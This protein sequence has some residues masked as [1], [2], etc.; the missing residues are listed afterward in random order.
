MLEDDKTLI[1][2]FELGDEFSQ[3]A[4][5][6]KE[7]LEPVLL[8]QTEDNPDALI[9]TV[10]TPDYGEPIRGFVELVRRGEP[11]VTGERQTD[12]VRVLAYFFRKTLELTRKR[13]PTEKIRLMCVT[14]EEMD[15]DFVDRIY[16]ALS[17]IGLE[18][19]RVRVVDHKRSYMYYVL[20][21]K[22][23]LWSSDVGLFD[24][25][26]RRLIYEQLQIDRAHQPALM[27]VKKTDY[28]DAFAS[29][30]DSVPKAS[31]FENI[32]HSALRN[33][34]VS[35]IFMTGD[36]FEE[37][38]TDEVFPRLAVGR[39][40]FKGRNL[41][42]SGAAYCAKEFVQERFSDFVVVSPDMVSS[43]L[44]MEVYEEGKSNKIEFTSAG[45]PWFEVDEQVELI[46]DGDTELV[47]KADHIFDDSSREF[48]VDLTPILGRN[49]RMCRIA[50][51]LRFA[52]VK[53]A[54]LTIRD[55]GFGDIAP[56]SN[57]VWEEKITCL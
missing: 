24:Y 9:E 10:V 56:G 39:R 5:Y 53:R 50:L 26:G 13:Y 47:I 19:D 29:E 33:Q 27:R 36:G 14:V 40:L 41:Y 8:G 6:D 11:V 38:W 55:L 3:I 46:P 45:I 52:D 49:E 43:R 15:K 48:I 1:V 30:D 31:I 18:S 7:L 2:G 17:L 44:S 20:Y 51:R 28:T 35:A 32:V 54:V 21:Q 57:R 23:E 34:F 42:V 4:V 25:D 16:E 22:K 12:S 37:E